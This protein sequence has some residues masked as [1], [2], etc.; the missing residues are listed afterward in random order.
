MNIIYY[1]SVCFL[2]IIGNYYV[3]PRLYLAHSMSSIIQS[4]CTM[5]NTKARTLAV[6]SA[7]NDKMH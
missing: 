4:V 3:T 2:L 7:L 5:F 6:L 1:T